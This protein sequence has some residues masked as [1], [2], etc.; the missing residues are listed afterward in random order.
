LSNLRVLTFNSHQPY[1]HLLAA[2]LPWTLGVISPRHPSGA[3]KRWDPR[4]RPLP[5]NIRLFTSVNEALHDS[6][7]DWVLAHNVHDLIDF[8]EVPLPKVF[9]VHGTISGRILQDRSNIGRELYI[10]NIR[11]LM[12]A[13]GSHVVYI[14]D[15]KRRDWG[16]PGDVIR[17]AVDD[18]QYGEYC[19]EVRGILQVCNRLKERGRMM[20]WNIHQA[21]CRDL[22]SLVLGENPTLPS[23]R[24]AS[25]WEDLKAQLRSYR[26]YLYTPIYPYEDG[27][28]LALLEA[29]ATGMPV[30]TM[31]HITSPI[32]DGLEGVVAS[33]AEELR[34]MVVRLLDNPAEAAEMGRRA[35][36]RVQQEFS[37]PAFRSLWE[38]FAQRIT[39]A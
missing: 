24:M 14:S 39:S 29:M 18:S 26:I 5:E 36:A 9:L 8:R 13:N 15:L 34:E 17:S 19:G 6:V 16:I 35:R 11:L 27:Y 12:E 22:P 33:S 38:S 30:A 3:V 28:N 21:V 25:N 20:G 32:R 4:I 7:W 23:S 2:S 31:Q 10:K 1:L 37:V